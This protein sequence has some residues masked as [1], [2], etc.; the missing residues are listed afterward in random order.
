LISAK[1]RFHNSEPDL[2]KYAARLKKVSVRFAFRR[3][4][5]GLFRRGGPVVPALPG[6][7]KKSHE[8]ST[9]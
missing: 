7:S 1:S 3:P 5:R 2:Q 9:A 8:G 6:V 4:F